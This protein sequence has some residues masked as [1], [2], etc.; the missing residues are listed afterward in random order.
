M[1]T[2][3]ITVEGKASLLMHRWAEA[4]ELQGDGTRPMKIQEMLPRDQA[5]M[6]AYR[7]EADGRL[8]VPGAMFA[9]LLREAGSAYKDKGSR[10]SV[11]FVVPGA[12]LVTEDAIDL[13][14]KDGMPIYKFEV[15][16]RPVVI[17]ST[18]GRIM[19]YRPRIEQWRATFHL[20][21]DDALISPTLV[22]TMLTEGGTRLGIADFRPEKGGP[23]GRF[24]VLLWQDTR[25]PKEQRKWGPP[26][27]TGPEGGPDPVNGQYERVDP[28][29]AMAEAEE[30]E[31]E[32]EAPSPRGRRK[33]SEASPDEP[34][35]DWQDEPKKP[36]GRPRK[37]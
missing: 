20:E 25:P 18:K 29:E 10:K 1:P 16:G 24:N 6:C 5:E 31:E 12:C 3:Q 17:P 15:D 19:R 27:A 30:A 9:R 26:D 14:D 11:K 4:S 7:R 37:G 21:V 23:F 36:R 34:V 8:Y 13:H 32:G 22:H 35:T 2:Y 33:A 28:R